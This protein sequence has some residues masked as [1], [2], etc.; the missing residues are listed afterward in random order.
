MPGEK[1]DVKN[2]KF[3]IGEQFV[4]R[5]T[6]ERGYIVN[7]FRACVVNL[8]R[9]VRVIPEENLLL[10]AELESNPI[11]D[12]TK[13][14]FVKGDIVRII[15]TEKTVVTGTVI[16][17]R[18]FYVVHLYKTGELKVVLAE[19][20]AKGNL[21]IIPFV[22]IPTINIKDLPGQGKLFKGR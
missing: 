19:M 13:A 22:T 6:G 15:P 10:E 9:A 2:P 4:S 1:E 3:K 12:H 16:D 18:W 17:S 5:I 7:S 14:T 21:K 20:L 8:K 11:F